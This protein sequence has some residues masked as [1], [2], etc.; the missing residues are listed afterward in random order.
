MLYTAFELSGEDTP[1]DSPATN[2]LPQMNDQS[3]WQHSP[4]AN[5]LPLSHALK[6]PTPSYPRKLDTTDDK[7]SWHNMSERHA[8]TLPTT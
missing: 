6:D 1:T 3:L 7:C 8:Q 2:K 5:S 4:S